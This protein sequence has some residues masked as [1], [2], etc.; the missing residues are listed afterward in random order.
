MAFINVTDQN[1]KKEEEKLP[2]DINPSIE[3]WRKK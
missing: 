2:K 1:F 3:C